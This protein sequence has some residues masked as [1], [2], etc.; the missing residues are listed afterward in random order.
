MTR[1]RI[2]PLLLF[3]LAVTSATAQ[4]QTGACPTTDPGFV[5]NPTNGCFVPNLTEHNQAADP[6]TGAL[7]VS[8]YDVLFFSEGANVATATPIQTTAIGKPTPNAQGAIWYG[9]GTPVPL[10][11]YPIG[12]R[13]KAVVVAVGAGGSSPRGSANTSNPFG[14]GAPVTAP[15]APSQHTLTAAG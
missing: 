4:A 10:P 1:I 9:A 5:I 7:K 12:Q 15:A 8:R 14:Q 13:L 3:A 2:V 6:V 11:S